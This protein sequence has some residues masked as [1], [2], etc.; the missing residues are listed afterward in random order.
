MARGWTQTR[1]AAEIGMAQHRLSTIERP[2]TSPRLD[3]LRRVARA[4]DV[5]IDELVSAEAVPA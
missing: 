4:L 1:L 3:T 5:S 2:D